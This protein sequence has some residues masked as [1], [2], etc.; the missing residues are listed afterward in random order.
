MDTSHGY[1]QIRLAK[2]VKSH[3]NCPDTFVVVVIG[4]SSA[5]DLFHDRI[6]VVLDG[7]PG[8]TSIHDNI[9]VWVSTL[10]NIKKTDS[11]KVNRES[12]NY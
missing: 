6:K 10:R 7:L 9:L 8:C 4:T 1:N 11:S 3:I 2:E 5:T 12:H